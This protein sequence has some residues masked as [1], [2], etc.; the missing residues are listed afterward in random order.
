MR[1]YS[2]CVY[3]IKCPDTL[4]V[5]YVGMTD[6]PIMRFRSHRFGRQS[7]VSKWIGEL[8]KNGKSPIIEIVKNFNLKRNDK[9]QFDK[10]RDRRIRM[11]EFETSLIKKYFRAGHP[12]FNRFGKIAS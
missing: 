11:S 6:D 2:P 12:L 4:L 3:I 7:D 1:P 8:F 9:R 10:K 5:R